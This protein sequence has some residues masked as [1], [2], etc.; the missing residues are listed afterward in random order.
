[1]RHSRSSPRSRPRTHR[2]R[3]ARRRLAWRCPARPRSPPPVRRSRRAGR[4][5]GRRT[6]ASS[7]AT[8]P[9]PGGQRADGATID[10]LVIRRFAK[11]PRL[12]LTV[13]TIGLAQLL[14]V[15]ELGLP[16][17]FNYDS[18]PQPPT[19]IH[20]RFEWSPVTFNGGHL[21]ILIVVP[22]ATAAV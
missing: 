18:V 19:P 14:Q 15:V 2:P 16:K 7:S 4:R 1:M 21:L 20:F 13:V 5:T 10:V 11:A 6:L 17:L 12:Q 3:S 9:C 22:A 8:S